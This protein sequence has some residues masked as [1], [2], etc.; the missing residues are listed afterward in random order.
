MI[1]GDIET[2]SAELANGGAATVAY[3]LGCESAS[4]DSDDVKDG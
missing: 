4:A 2:H 3:E 1:L